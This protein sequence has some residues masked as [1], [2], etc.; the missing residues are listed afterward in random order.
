VAKK[1]KATLRA[2]DFCARF[3]GEEFLAVLPATETPAAYE[4]AEKLRRTVESSP[5]PVAGR[6]TVSIGLAVADPDQANEG[7]AVRAADDNLY[8]AKESGRNTVVFSKAKA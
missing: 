3:G 6:I 7:V 8:K 2:S 4:V 1:L 5:D